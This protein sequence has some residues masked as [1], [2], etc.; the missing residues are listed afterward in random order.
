LADQ[1]SIGQ[2]MNRRQLRFIADALHPGDVFLDIGAYIGLYSL[3][4]AKIVGSTGR[5]VAFEPYPGS[6]EI[7]T[8]NISLNRLEAIVA[9]ESYAVGN[10]AGARELRAAGV[11]SA[12]TLTPTSVKAFGEGQAVSA[13]PVSMIT[14]D[15]YCQRRQIFPTCIKIDVEGWELEVLRGMEQ[16]LRSDAIVVCEMHPQLWSDSDLTEREVFGQLERLGRYPADLDGTRATR[17]DYGPYVFKK[18]ILGG[19]REVCAMPEGN[20][21]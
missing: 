4:A 16:L 19:G 1:A 8:K 7:L 11:C 15:E 2:E 18:E 3:L 12:N 21:E 20:F 6:R 13:V 9:V 14:L 17:L 5:V 10:E